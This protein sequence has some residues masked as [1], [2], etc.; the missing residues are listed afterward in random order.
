MPARLP[1]TL[2]ARELSQELEGEEILRDVSLVVGPAT[3]LGVVGPNGVG[4]STLLKLLAGLAVPRSGTV[5]LIPPTGSVGYLAQEPERSESETVGHYLARATGVAEA[6]LRLQAGT[7]HL[8]GGVPG[9]AGQYAEALERWE[10]LGAP[11]FEARTET[12]LSSFGLPIELLGVPTAALSGGQ[13]ASVSL[14][15]I[16]L[17]RFDITLLDEPTNNLDFSALS[18]LEH[19]VL[20]REGGVVVV[21]HDRA[22]LE[23]TVTSVL[24][25]DEHQRCGRLFN[26]GWAAYLDERRLARAQ[27]EEQYLTYE[28]RRQSLVERARR[29]KQWATTGVSRERSQPRDNDKAQRNFRINRTEQLASRARRTE[30]ALERLGTVEKPWESWDLRLHIGQARRAGQVV[31]KLSQAVVERGSFR[32]GPVDVEVNWGER[33]GLVGPNGSGKTTL[34]EALLGRLPL[35]AGRAWLGPSVVVGELEQGRTSYL[36]GESLLATF[37]HRTGLDQPAARSLLAKFGLGPRHVLRPAASLSPGERTRAILATFQA[38]QVNFLVLDEPTNHLDLPAV[39]QLES[40]LES[41]TGALLLVTHDRRLIGSV[42]LD[43]S[44]DVTSF[45]TPQ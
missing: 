5:D 43:R 13:A 1:V 38:T 40:A 36:T 16:L 41:F 23:N 27:A 44:T 39:E 34:V 29:E 20:T 26:G 17:S 3:R 2:V 19:F 4:K 30:Q 8:A 14:A 12:L 28:V 45:G 25:I 35:A 24:E 21:S 33:V 22:F 11:G 42:R 10:A 6:E 18:R 7:Q 37:R 31:A 15:A 9:A 32:L